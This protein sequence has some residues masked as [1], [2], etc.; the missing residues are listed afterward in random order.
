MRGERGVGAHGSGAWKIYVWIVKVA[1]NVS[2]PSRGG[3]HRSALEPGLA[4]CP[5]FAHGC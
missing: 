2:P 3:V 5:A 1:T 4:L